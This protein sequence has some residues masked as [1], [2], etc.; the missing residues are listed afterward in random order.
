M[1]SA[2]VRL[3]DVNGACFEIRTEVTPR[4]EPFAECDGRADEPGKV[5][6]LMRVARQ[7]GLYLRHEFTM[8]GSHHQR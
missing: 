7:E 5:R 1:G 2:Y 8:G 6:C 4:E 3:R